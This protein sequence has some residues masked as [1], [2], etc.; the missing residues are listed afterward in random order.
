MVLQKQVVPVP[1]SGGLDT[2]TDP[3]QLPPGKLLVAENVVMQRTGE[4]KKADGTTTLTTAVQGGGNILAGT[5]ISTL[6]SEVC[7]STQVSF[8]GYSPNQGAWLNRGS[9]INCTVSTSTV[10]TGTGSLKF[11][12]AAVA[13][14]I[15]VYAWVDPSLDSGQG[16]VV[17]TVIDLISGAPIVA[18][19]ALANSRTAPRIITQGST[20]FLTWFTNGSSLYGL[21]IPSANPVSSSFFPVVASSATVHYDICPFQ[22]GMAV[23]YATTSYDLYAGQFNTSG[24]QTVSY[25]SLGVNIAANT[26]VIGPQSTMTPDTIAAPRVTLFPSDNSAF[27]G[28]L[29]C[30]VIAGTGTPLYHATLNAAFGYNTSAIMIDSGSAGSYSFM[31]FSAINING[32]SAIFYNRYASGA[33][34]NVFPLYRSSVQLSTNTQVVNNVVFSNAVVTSR[35]FSLGGTPMVMAGYDSSTLD[36]VL[37]TDGLQSANFLV[38]DAGTIQAAILPDG[39]S[40]PRAFQFTTPCFATSQKIIFPVLQKTRVVSDNGRLFGVSAVASSTVDFTPRPFP[41]GQVL[42]PNLYLPGGYLRTYDGVGLVEAGFH[43]A[44]E[45]K[46]VTSG[47]SGGA[48]GAGSYLYRA[49]YEWRD[50]NGQLQQSAPSAPLSVTMSGSTNTQTVSVTTLSLTEKLAEKGR[51]DVSIVL[52]RTLANGTVFYRVTSQTSPVLNTAAARSTGKVTITDTLS[53]AAIASNQILYTVGGE[54]EN[55]NGPSPTLILSFKNRLFA[56]TGEDP[57]AVYY[58]KELIQGLAPAFNDTLRISVNPQFGNITALGSLDDKLVIFKPAAIYVV[59]GDGPL[60]NGQQNTFSEAAKIASD[61]G[62]TNPSSVVETPLGLMFQSAKGIYLLDRSLSVQY[63]GAPVEAFNSLTVSGA[64]VLPYANQVRFTT[65][66]GTTLVFD[67][68][69][70]VWTVRTGEA[71]VGAVSWNGQAAYLRSNGQVAVETSGQNN[72]DGAAVLTKVKTGFYSF[73]GLQG[74][75]RVWRVLVLGEFE[76][77]HVLKV[78]IFTDYKQTAD[79]TFYV[80]VGDSSFCSQASVRALTTQAATFTGG[81]SDTAYQFAVKPRVQ[82]C[83]AMAVQIEDAFP[84][85]TPTKGMNISSVSFEVGAKGTLK[86][87]SASA[88]MLKG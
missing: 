24:T 40:G 21:L 68:V 19:V 82:K 53:D 5:Q 69:Q 55:I 9:L 58:S 16:M 78:S 50:S 25:V 30:P 56:L 2:K 72:S 7:V 23:V 41:S 4:L 22:G 43:V 57:S 85:G 48:I 6:G 59:A 1:L 67:Y 13:G 81:A 42:G 71:A 36:A 38:T 20:I 49:V 17:Y 65:T 45:L 77:N 87:L 47:A 8:C 61:V 28:L 60:P 79:D 29:Y 35:A 46:S 12:C 44:P 80:A 32:I 62:C 3:K 10:G 64:F 86:K 26:S 11:P 33:T 27:I 31:C 54:V 76:G 63:I 39:R 66:Q 37:S 15:A 73:A 74:F 75:Q 14:N 84:T 52:Y 83:E 70:S 88:N 51:N 34:S 18:P